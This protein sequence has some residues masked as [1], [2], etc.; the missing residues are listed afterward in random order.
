MGVIFLMFYDIHS[1]MINRYGIYYKLTSAKGGVSV[2]SLLSQLTDQ[3]K[4]QPTQ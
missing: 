1:I 4:R 3:E 2:L